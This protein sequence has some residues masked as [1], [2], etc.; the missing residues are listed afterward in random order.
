MPLAKVLGN[1][2]VVVVRNHS[3]IS[4]SKQ[5]LKATTNLSTL[6]PTSSPCLP[7]SYKLKSAILGTIQR[8]WEGLGTYV[9]L[10]VKSLP[11]VV[12]SAKDYS[13]K[14]VSEIT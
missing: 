10:T 7:C 3:V 4:T 2:T 12:P 6:G 11:Y 1:H 13:S 9:G 14:E 8:L 5:I